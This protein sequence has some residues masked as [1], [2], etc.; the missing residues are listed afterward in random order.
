VTE[1]FKFQLVSLLKLYAATIEH[2]NESPEANDLRESMDN[3][4]WY[5]LTQEEQEELRSLGGAID[6]VE[7]RPRAT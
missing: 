3:G 5:R 2:G 6:A 4:S 1:D 7:S